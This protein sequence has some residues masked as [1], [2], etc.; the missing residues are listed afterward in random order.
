M[1]HGTKSKMDMEYEAENDAR[2][3]RDAMAVRK[4]SKRL[5]AAHV[6]LQKMEK[7]AHQTLMQTRAARGL[8]RA[9]PKDNPGH[10]EGY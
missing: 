7:E 5:K 10:K 1:T 2:A 8:K 6:A 3:L 4:D 9:F